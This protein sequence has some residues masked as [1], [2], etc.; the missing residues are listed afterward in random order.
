MRRPLT[1]PRLRTVYDAGLPDRLKSIIQECE[2]ERVVE[3]LDAAGLCFD[4]LMGHGVGRPEGLVD[5]DLARVQ[6]VQLSKLVSVM[7]RAC[8]RVCVS[9][10]LHLWRPI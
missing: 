1:C 2:E 3:V 6:R 10:S 8:V 7:A 5:S 9:R 4:G